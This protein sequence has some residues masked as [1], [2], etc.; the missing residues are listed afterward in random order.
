MLH[1]RNGVEKSTTS[2]EP[3][4]K[5]L[6]RGALNWTP[7]FPEGEDDVS[8]AK[9]VEYMQNEWT[10]RNPDTVKIRKRMALTFPG[11]RRFMNVPR[12]VVDVKSEYPGLFDEKEVNFYLNY[13][14]K[15]IF[16]CLF[17]QIVL[18][19]NGSSS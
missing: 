9:H 16:P 3:V 4:K 15:K 5:G 18:L 19:G 17:A 7:P 13:Q 8:L 12:A 14:F 1:K 11:R 6:K 2:S 10:R